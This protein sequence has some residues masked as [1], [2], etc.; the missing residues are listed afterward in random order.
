MGDYFLKDKFPTDH[1][2]DENTYNLNFVPKKTCK[3]VRLG[4]RFTLIGHQFVLM[5]YSNNFSSISFAALIQNKFYETQ[6][7]FFYRFFM[8]R[9]VL[10]TRI[11]L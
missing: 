1:Q 5:G 10:W 7:T 6:I 2:P 3:N 9:M 4:Y 8:E 11:Q